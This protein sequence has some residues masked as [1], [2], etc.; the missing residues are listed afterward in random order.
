MQRR[1]L[2]KK[3]ITATGETYTSTEYRGVW[4]RKVP[5]GKDHRGVT[6]FVDLATAQ[7]LR[8]LDIYSISVLGRMSNGKSLQVTDQQGMIRCFSFKEEPSEPSF[9]VML[10]RTELIDY[11]LCFRAKFVDG[12]IYEITE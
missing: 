9:P 12:V 3:L 2:M 8:H 11:E 5:D 1:L 10:L 7:A 6:V 4:D